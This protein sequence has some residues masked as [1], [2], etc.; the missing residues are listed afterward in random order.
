M[1]H[2]YIPTTHTFLLQQRP[3]PMAPVPTGGPPTSSFC[4]CNNYCNTRGCNTC[5]R[6]FIPK[7]ANM[8]TKNKMAGAFLVTAAAA[9]LIPGERRRNLRSED[10]PLIGPTSTKFSPAVPSGSNQGDNV[11]WSRHRGDSKECP[12][13][14]YNS[15]KNLI[16]HWDNAP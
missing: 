11:R 13:Y 14:T 15:T 9:V 8:T 3:C 12:P 4:C 10:V 16:R 2:T 1:G 7:R 5:C 6:S